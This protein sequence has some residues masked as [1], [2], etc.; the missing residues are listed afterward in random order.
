MRRKIRLLSQ[1]NRRHSDERETPMSA[2][3]L[4]SLHICAI[5]LIN[6]GRPMAFLLLFRFPSD[7]RPATTRVFAKGDD[8]K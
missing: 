6:K 1:F 8:R 4:L 5:S 7:D 3:W 2:A